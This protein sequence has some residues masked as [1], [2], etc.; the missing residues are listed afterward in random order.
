MVTRTAGGRARLSQLASTAELFDAVRR[1]QPLAVVLDVPIGLPE[2][3]SRR[4]DLEAR[5]LLRPRSACVFPAPP[6]QL[7]G[8]GSQSEASQIWRRLYG[9]GCPAQTYGIL[10]RIRAVDQE[11]EGELVERAHEGH[12]ELS[13]LQMAGGRGLPSKHSPEGMTRRIKLLASDFP[14]ARAWTKA[15]WSLRLDVLDAC[16]CR[17]RRRHRS[18]PHRPAERRHGGGFARSHRNQWLALPRHLPAE[19]AA[20]RHSRQVGTG[21]DHLTACCIGFAPHSLTPER[22]SATRSCR[23]FRAATSHLRVAARSGGYRLRPAMCTSF[24]TWRPATTP[25]R[26]Q[27]PA[28]SDW[29]RCWMAQQV[30][31]PDPGR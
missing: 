3:G 28:A 17:D 9:R 21:H 23:H 15:R 11:L 18:I 31:A 22:W 14:E 24:T 29:I 7:L 4:C 26:R 6:R 25:C 30:S 8:A 5:Q 16:A 27:Q 12:P 13:F 10:A 19:P 20:L 1:L 2:S